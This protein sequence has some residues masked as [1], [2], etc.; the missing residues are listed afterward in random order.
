MNELEVGG[1]VIV[2]M[3][4]VQVRVMIFAFEGIGPI[5]YGLVGF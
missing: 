4:S 2:V 1:S 3:H 5:T